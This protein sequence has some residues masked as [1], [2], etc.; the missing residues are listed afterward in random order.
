MKKPKFSKKGITPVAAIFLLLTVTIVGIINFQSWFALFQSN[1]FVEVETQSNSDL[2][3]MIETIVGER[4]YIKT[5][6]QLLNVNKIE[7]DGVDCEFNGTISNMQPI[8][9]SSCLENINTKVSEILVITDKGVI[10][11]NVFLNQYTISPEIQQ[12]NC[13]NEYLFFDSINNLHWHR[14]LSLTGQ[15]QWAIVGNYDQPIWNTSTNSYI[16]PLG[17]SSSD[18]PAFEYC[19]NLVLCSYNDWRLSGRHEMLSLGY[20]LVGGWGEFN[21]TNAGFFNF[22]HDTPRFRAREQ[23]TP[24]GGTIYSYAWYVRF[25]DGY[26]TRSY[27][28]A[29]KTNPL[30][31][32]CVRDII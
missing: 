23:R 15:H 32:M 31:L 6:N 3:T 25:T 21:F 26:N 12:I 7:V 27:G 20:D 1:V 9:V 17:R 29:L 22:P 8:D 28:Q 4:L 13:V 5:G 11:K 19:E 30:Y 14:N 18:Y 2:H 10:T 24:Y 16:Y